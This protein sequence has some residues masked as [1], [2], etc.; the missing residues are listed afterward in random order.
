M[1]AIGNNDPIFPKQVL[2]DL[3]SAQKVK[4]S[5]GNYN[6]NI[7]KEHGTTFTNKQWRYICSIWSDKDYIIKND[8]FGYN[9][10]WEGVEHTEKKNMTQERKWNNSGYKSL[11]RISF[12]VQTA[13]EP[14]EKD[15]NVKIGDICKG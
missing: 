6:C 2:E 9:I 10:H 4:D 1:L 5:T 7:K 15:V 3:Q 11:K 14:D 13:K 12:P 8:W